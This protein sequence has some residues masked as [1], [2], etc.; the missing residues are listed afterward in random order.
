LSDQQTDVTKTKPNALVCG[1]DVVGGGYLSFLYVLFQLLYSFTL[2]ALTI[3]FDNAR[4]YN[5]F[6]ILDI[7]R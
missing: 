5:I 6:Y 7:T 4:A 3:R 1:C 2:I